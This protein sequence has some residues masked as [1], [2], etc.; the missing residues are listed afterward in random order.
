MAKKTELQF[1]CHV[2]SRR[3]G[4]DGGESWSN[5]THFLSYT[6]AMEAGA[7]WTLYQ[8]LIHGYRQDDRQLELNLNLEYLILIWNTWNGQWSKTQHTDI[9]GPC[10]ASVFNF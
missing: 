9:Y 3:C 8:V 10:S 7:F 6:N 5:N 4:A 1:S 2:A